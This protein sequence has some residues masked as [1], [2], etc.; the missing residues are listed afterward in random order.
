M[1]IMSQDEYLNSLSQEDISA[2]VD[3]VVD[4]AISENINLPKQ[5]SFTTQKAAF[6]LSNPVTSFIQNGP[7]EQIATNP[8]FDPLTPLIGTEYEPDLNKF[9]Y[10]DNDSEVEAVKQ[11]IDHE[12]RLREI[13][14]KGESLDVILGSVAGGA[15]DPTIVVPALSIYKAGKI[16]ITA[17][18]V[19]G[20]AAVGAGVMAAQEAA[21]QGSQVL[22][23]KE[24]SMINIAAG[25]VLG[26]AIGGAIGLVN[27]AALAKN[28]ELVASIL[29][30]TYNTSDQWGNIK[31]SAG[32]A[33]VGAPADAS[34]ANLPNWVVKAVQIPGM[35]SPVLEGLTSSS[36]AM[37]DLT[38][39]MFESP[40]MLKKNFPTKDSPFGSP[41][42][43]PIDLKLQADQVQ[44]LDLVQ[45]NEDLYVAY[46][47]TKQPEGVKPLSRREFD[48]EV[49][50]AYNRGDK[51]HIPEVEAAA[52][53]IRED[54]KKVNK[55][56]EEL[57]ILS[58]EEVKT[59]DQGD[60][61]RVWDREAVIANRLEL[62]QIL[63]EH[64]SQGA[65]AALVKAKQT[66]GEGQDELIRILGEKA[67]SSSIEAQ[68]SIETIL[69]RGDGEVE[70]SDLASSEV[71]RID[72]DR[73]VRFTKK[74]TI[75]IP[76]SKV[77]K[78]L[79]RDM[80][81][82]AGLYVQQANQLI[83][84]REFLNEVG[85]KSP[86]DLISKLKSEYERSL[87]RIPKDNPKIDFNLE[88]KQLGKEYDK[89]EALLK[90]FIKISLGQYHVRTGADKFFRLL[91]QYN[92]VRLMGQVTISS[93]PDIAM[94]IIKHGLGRT[95]TDG[96]VAN[97]KQVAEGTRKM[98][99]KDLRAMAIGIEAES[100]N[101]LRMILDPDFSTH[102]KTGYEKVAETATS[103]HSKLSGIAY[104]NMMNNRTAA[105]IAGN[106]I[107]DD[108]MGFEKLGSN[109][110]A[111]LNSLGIGESHVNA[112]RAEMKAGKLK[113]VKSAWIFDTQSWT[114]RRAAD[115]MNAAM[116]KEVQ[117]T[118][119]VAGKALTPRLIQKYS[120]VQTLMQFKGYFAAATAKI[121]LSGLQRR[122]ANV[123]QGVLALLGLGAAQYITISRLH[124]REPDLSADKLLLEGINRSGLLGLIGDPLF[125]FVLRPWVQSSRYMNQNR[126]EYFMGPSSSILK[127][128]IGIYDR[129]VMNERKGND[130][131]DEKTLQ[132]AGKLVPFQN[133]FYLQMFLNKLKE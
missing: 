23:T 35:R 5:D 131:F 123:A 108:I 37:R 133:L 15:L 121:L 111:Y 96:Y 43:I 58:K 1:P 120:A 128:L 125:G 33:E 18:N 16:G 53:S 61:T 11:Q 30:G 9:I 115:A 92:Y 62:E 126:L 90:D 112:I 41:T 118:T 105:V 39:R 36:P 80:T 57:E 32:A 54:I 6:Q 56:L 97:L 28:N 67:E 122:D 132:D 93:M 64:Y 109:E 106:R 60:M 110:I 95:F 76:N 3:P 38:Q 25:A 27:K 50:K 101:A 107:M 72:V 44:V 59:I 2:R 48:E 55:K 85:A 40:L 21:L 17:A 104:W 42:D 87:D 116:L 77:E 51:S 68:Q 83:R 34:I 65:A 7:V 86:E 49:F 14:S 66:K 79:K 100:N 20:N 13:V 75:D 29:K 129:A 8:D 26:G 130:I 4:E 124:G 88:A 82:I 113:K 91:N 103:V 19:L 119:I 63:N 84:F 89:N 31:M 22:R 10:A 69:G 117:S 74:R 81:A 24:E 94:P 71:A 45:R 52:K 70:L 99:N 73:G 46:R 102:L 98:V 12:K 114:N 47:T 78:F 127:P